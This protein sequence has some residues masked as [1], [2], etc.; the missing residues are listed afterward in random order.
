MTGKIIRKT[1]FALAVSAW[2]KWKPWARVFFLA[3]LLVPAAT[4]GIFKAIYGGWTG[5][6]LIVGDQILA[7]NAGLFGLE[8]PVSLPP[9]MG[10]V[11]LLTLGI[12]ATFAL[13]Q[14][15]RA[16]EVVS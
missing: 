5:S 1:P 14:R 8:S 2:V 15:I 16:F 13:Y 10:W 11:A 3:M 6:L 7:V 4:G 12:F 9:V